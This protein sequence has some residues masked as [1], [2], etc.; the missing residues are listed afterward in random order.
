[1]NSCYFCHLY[2][3][4]VLWHS[5]R[6]FFSFLHSFHFLTIFFFPARGERDLVCTLLSSVY[7]SACL[8]RSGISILCCQPQELKT[9]VTLHLCSFKFHQCPVLV[10]SKPGFMEWTGRPSLHFSSDLHLGLEWW[11]QR[12]PKPH[13]VVEH[14][15]AIKL[16]VATGCC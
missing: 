14:S 10:N 16:L 4:M 6:L 5:H 11:R 13:W 3:Q 9:K 1:M 12:D 8:C 2:L 15:L 7:Y